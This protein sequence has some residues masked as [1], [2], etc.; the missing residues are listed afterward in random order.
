MAVQEL[1]ALVN[2][3]Q[4]D[5]DKSSMFV[6]GQDEELEL[7]QKEIH[8]LEQKISQAGEF[9]R[10]SLESELT[11]EKDAYQFLHETLVGQQRNLQEKESVLRQHRMV[12]ARRQGKP[13]PQEDGVVDLSPVVSQVDSFKQQQQEQLHQIEGQVEQ[14][15]TP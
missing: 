10:I 11:D 8:D 13:L 5:F 4:S 3:L 1:E 6:K 15:R 9:D 14:A 7:K 12:L 2:N